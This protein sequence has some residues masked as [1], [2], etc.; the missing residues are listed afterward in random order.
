M[1]EFKCN[2]RFFFHKTIY[3]NLK[4]TKKN[5]VHSTVRVLNNFYIKYCTVLVGFTISLLSTKIYV[6][7][8]LWPQKREL[9]FTDLK[10]VLSNFNIELDLILQSTATL[11]E[12]FMLWRVRKKVSIP[13]KAPEAPLFEYVN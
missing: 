12:F 8:T 1:V 2:S 4:K 3:L 7:F 10:T 11:N 13:L 6:C 5:S 9:A